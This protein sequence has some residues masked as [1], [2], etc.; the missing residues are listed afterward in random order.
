MRMNVGNEVVANEVLN[1]YPAVQG[2]TNSCSEATCPAVFLNTVTFYW[3]DKWHLHAC[4]PSYGVRHL[5]A[6]FEAVS[7]IQAAIF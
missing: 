6:T 5:T 7:E 3:A 4:F 1:I 2:Y